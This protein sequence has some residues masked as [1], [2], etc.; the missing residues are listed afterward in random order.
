VPRLKH[1]HVQDTE[2]AHGK[3]TRAVAALW[4]LSTPPPSSLVQGI[5]ALPGYWSSSTSASTAE[6][7]FYA[8]RRDAACLPGPG[9]IT[10]TVAVPRSVCASGY[11]VG[12]PALDFSQSCRRAVR[13]AA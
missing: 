3:H 7:Q 4:P 5:V 2:R 11:E 13:S 10:S 8:C 12:G 6:P 1:A 9:A